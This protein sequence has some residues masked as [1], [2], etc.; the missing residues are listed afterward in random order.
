VSPN[1][2]PLERELDAF[3]MKVRD[4]TA[5]NAWK[6]AAD[7]LIDAVLSDYQA[8]TGK[9]ADIVETSSSN[10]SYLFDVST[11]RLVA[12]YGVSKGKHTGRRDSVRMRGSPLGGPKGYHRGHAIP[13]TLGGPLDINLVPQNGEVNVGKFRT[14][15]IEA[16]NTPGAFYFTYWKYPPTSSQ[17][18]TGVFQGLLV[19]GQAAKITEH[20]N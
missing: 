20:R 15:E 5:P 4:G 7:R 18:P 11:Q 9:P 16:V 1:R 3:A 17:R 13:H 8:A 14:L 6:D 2:T 19:P 12:A 10:F